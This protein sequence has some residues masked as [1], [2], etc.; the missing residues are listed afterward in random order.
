MLRQL[1][2][3]RIKPRIG[4]QLNKL[5]VKLLNACP[6]V[7]IFNFWMNPY[8]VIVRNGNQTAV[9]GP[10]EGRGEGNPIGDGIVIRLGKRHNVTGIHHRNTS[11]K[12]YFHPAHR[13]PLIVL[14]QNGLLEDMELKQLT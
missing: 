7:I 1:L 5:A 10:V 14:L 13:T 6:G 12:A 11:I 3:R 9:K 4:R 8:L 2:L